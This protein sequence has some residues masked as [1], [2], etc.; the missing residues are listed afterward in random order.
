MPKIHSRIPSRSPDG[1]CG[2]RGEI[3]MTVTRMTY[4]FVQGCYM[5]SA[6]RILG[7]VELLFLPRTCGRI[8]ATVKN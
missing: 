2:A 8:P 3:R 1:W 6:A 7:E 4:S 5:W